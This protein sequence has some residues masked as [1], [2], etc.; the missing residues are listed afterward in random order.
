MR[1][2]RLPRWKF[3]DC[4]NSLPKSPTP[5]N[6]RDFVKTAALG[7]AGLAA[8]STSTESSS[9]QNPRNF[10]PPPPAVSPIEDL[11]D[12]H[13]HSAPGHQGSRS[14]A[15]RAGHRPGADRQSFARR[16]PA[17]VRQRADG[18]GHHQGPDQ[19]DGAG[20]DGRV[21]DGLKPGGKITFGGDSAR[22]VCALTVRASVQPRRACLP[23][24]AVDS[25]QGLWRL[26][27]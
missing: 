8:L 21:A 16:R 19:A 20:N 26:P 14:A 18:A 13:F 5:T 11:I 10:P 12:T 15:L 2:C 3:T 17:D 23:P 22:R 7:I 1:P 24:S 27:R 4:C 9:A 6:R 25:R